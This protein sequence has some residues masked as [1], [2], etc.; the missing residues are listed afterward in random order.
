[1]TLTIYEFSKHVCVCKS[2]GELNYNHHQTLYHIL[3]IFYQFYSKKMIFISWKFHD[4]YD[5]IS[6]G[7]IS[8]II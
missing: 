1:M 7:K 4:A 6:C 5:N 8:N 3:H 2:M